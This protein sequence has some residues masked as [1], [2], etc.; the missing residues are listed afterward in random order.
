MIAATVSLTKSTNNNGN[1]Y[2]CIYIYLFI[3]AYS[4]METSFVIAQSNYTV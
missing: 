1:L 4:M 3:Y 2:I